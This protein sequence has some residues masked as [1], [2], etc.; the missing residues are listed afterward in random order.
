[1]NKTPFQD[2]ERRAKFGD[3]FSQVL[4][5]FFLEH[6]WRVAPDKE[7]ALQWYERAANQDFAPGQYAL[8]FLLDDSESER[9][10]LG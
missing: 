6:G 9:K 2:V 10:V 4:F 7:A 5:G 1:M 3:P 8:A